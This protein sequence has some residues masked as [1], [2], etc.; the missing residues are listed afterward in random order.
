MV[1]GAGWGTSGGCRAHRWGSGCWAKGRPRQGMGEEPSRGSLRDPMGFAGAVWGAKWGRMDSLRQVPQEH[2]LPDGESFSLVFLLTHMTT[3]SGANPSP[4]LLLLVPAQ[5]RRAAFLALKVFQAFSTFPLLLKGVVA[6]GLQFHPCSGQG[7]VLTSSLP[8][9]L[10]RGCIYQYSDVA[11]TIAPKSNGYHLKGLWTARKP[12]PPPTEPKHGGWGGGFCKMDLPV[13]RSSPAL[14]H[15]HLPL[16]H[17]QSLN[18][19]CSKN[20]A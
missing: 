5:T 4:F 15:G 12:P 11:I 17:L 19:S 1:S 9:T 13:L 2:R 6:V 10:A 20:T 7:I 16:R 3:V 14:T 18:Y 8:V